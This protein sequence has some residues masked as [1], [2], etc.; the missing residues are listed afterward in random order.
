MNRRDGIEKS[1]SRE[2]VQAIPMPCVPGRAR[3]KRR[4]SGD[5]PMLSTHN[6]AGSIGTFTQSGMTNYLGYQTP[7]M[8]LGKFPDHTEFFKLESEFQNASVFESEKSSS[9]YPVDL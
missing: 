5:C 8:H 1:E 9:R 3:R 7:E 2:P 4:D 6:H